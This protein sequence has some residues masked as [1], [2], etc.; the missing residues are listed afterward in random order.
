MERILLGGKLQLSKLRDAAAVATLTS[1]V[2]PLAVGLIVRA[3]YKLGQIEPSKRV[4]TNAR[5]NPP[6]TYLHL[7]GIGIQVIDCILCN[8]IAVFVEVKHSC[9]TCK[10][11]RLL[12]PCQCILPPQIGFGRLTIQLELD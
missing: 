9:Q 10:Y 8:P 2:E 11:I 4:P 5:Y 12:V 7:A 1:M 3:V 6:G